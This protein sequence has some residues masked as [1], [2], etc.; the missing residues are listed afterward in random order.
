LEAC[1]TDGN[2]NALEASRELGEKTVSFIADR[3]GQR[4]AKLLKEVE[5]E[6]A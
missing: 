5:T 6:E 4:A 2:P 3:L 1:V